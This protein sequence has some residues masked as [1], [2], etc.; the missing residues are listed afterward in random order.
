MVQPRVHLQEAYKLVKTNHQIRA[1]MVKKVK[2]KYH[3]TEKIWI[4]QQQ[5]NKY[6]TIESKLGLKM[7][8]WL[9]I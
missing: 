8:I 7:I 4:D 5:Q 3:V 1:T 2:N 9:A 6:Y